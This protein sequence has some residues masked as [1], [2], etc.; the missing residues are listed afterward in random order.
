MS[1]QS[2][3]K[4]KNIEIFSGKSVDEVFKTIYDFSVE[5]RTEALNT[6]KEFKKYV[7]DGDDLFMSGD[8]PQG[9]LDSAHKATENLIKL[10]TAA[11][12][13]VGIEEETKDGIDAST[14]LD[15]LESKGIAPERFIN[16]EGK[17]AAQQI[18]KE[19]DGKAMTIIEFPEI[20]KKSE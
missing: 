3:D 13:I 7:K 16:I 20:K 4:L 11:H 8:K 17:N 19:K 6:F 10:V 18:E 14:I 12:K 9:Y 5:E 1:Q 2:I 15:I